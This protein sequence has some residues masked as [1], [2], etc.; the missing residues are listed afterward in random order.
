MHTT[1]VLP[2]Q[3]AAKP[4]TSPRDRVSLPSSPSLLTAHEMSSPSERLWTIDLDTALKAMMI[5]LCRD[6]GLPHSS[7]KAQLVSQLRI[8][9]S[10]LPPPIMTSSTAISRPRQYRRL[11]L[12]HSP[13]SHQ[14]TTSPQRPPLAA[15]T[16][17]YS[18]ATPER[19]PLT[20]F[21]L[22]FRLL[23]VV[24]GSQMYLLL[25]CKF[26]PLEPHSHLHRPPKLLFQ[27]PFH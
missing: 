10:T 11:V 20:L 4:K 1:H 7:Q 3:S 18:L 24:P 9:Q 22:L 14:R 2:H 6:L 15:T 5:E 13:C 26:P 27:S 16:Q 23:L 25:P 8:R 17:R 21:S 12:A 19:H